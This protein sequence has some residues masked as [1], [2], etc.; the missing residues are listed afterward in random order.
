[1]S[2]RQRTD[3][4]YENLKRL[5]RYY[6]KRDSLPTIGAMDIVNMPEIVDLFPN[7][8]GRF[9]QVIRFCKKRDIALRDISKQE[10]LLNIFT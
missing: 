5:Y 3:D 6:I 2:Y 9:K 10:Q 8:S 7:E 1:M 4:N